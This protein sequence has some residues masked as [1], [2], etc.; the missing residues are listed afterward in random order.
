[1]PETVVRGAIRF[2][3]GCGADALRAVLDLGHQPPCDSL[4]RPERLGEPEIA[5]P[6]VF[7]RCGSCGL[8]QINYAVE[9]EVVFF[10][11]YPYQTSMTAS[12]RA[13][14]RR[15]TDEIAV[16]LRLGAED[17]AVDIGSNDG[18]LLKGFQEAGVRV[19]G[20][21]P[22][23]VAQI[24]NANGVPTVQTFF[25]EVAADTV[26]AEHGPA[27]VVTGTNMFAHIDNLYPALEAI[28]KLLRPDGVFVSESHYLLNLLDELQYDTIYHEHLR[29]YSLRPLRSRFRMKGP[30]R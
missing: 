10:P 15:L 2:C 6:L 21:E 24:A 30:A 13:H 20:I 29:F 8:A 16:R 14:F 22:T 4:V 7:C 18:T 26:L 3:Q 25:D 28:A 1:M 12:L 23:N 17:L 9:P 5:F 27:A 19:L 11:E